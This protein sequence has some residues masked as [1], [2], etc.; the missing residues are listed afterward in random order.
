MSNLVLRVKQH[1]H[2]L[3]FHPGRSFSTRNQF[4][5]HAIKRALGRGHVSYSSLNHAPLLQMSTWEGQ[6]QHLLEQ[7]RAHSMSQEVTLDRGNRVDLGEEG[8]MGVLPH[9]ATPDLFCCCCFL[10]GWFC[11][12]S[13]CFNHLHLPV[14]Q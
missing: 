7:S 2:D 12:L 3:H 13:S 5:G 10:F 6:V 1:L 14:I 8:P 9:P 4:W 11:S